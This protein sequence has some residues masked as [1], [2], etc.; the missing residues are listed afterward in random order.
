MPW[1]ETAA[2]AASAINLA[3]LKDHLRLTSSDE[4]GLLAFYADAASRLFE[5]KTRRVLIQRTFRLEQ[6]DFPGILDE[7]GIELPFAPVSAVSS[8]QYY[9]TD[10]TLTTWGSSNYYLDTVRLLPR[11]VLAPDKTYPTVDD[12]RPNGVQVNFTAGYGATYAAVPEPMRWA[13]MLIA[14]HMFTNR[15]TGEELPKALKYVVDAY[16]IWGA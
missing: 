2:P 14:A 11:V 10:G 7:R 5:I 9:E 3:D 12:D 4:D 8:V 1:T 6:P 13:V 15:T 16:K